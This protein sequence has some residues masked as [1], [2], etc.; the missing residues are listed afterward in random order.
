MIE[1]ENGFVLDVG[2]HYLLGPEVFRNTFELIRD[3]GLA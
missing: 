2:A 3:L 1:R